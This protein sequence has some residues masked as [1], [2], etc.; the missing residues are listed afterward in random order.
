MRSFWLI[1]FIVAALLL[2]CKSKKR[3]NEVCEGP[4]CECTGSDCICDEGGCRC[5][6]DDCQC[7]GE[8]CEDDSRASVDEP[9]P[10][11][12]TSGKELIAKGDGSVETDG[13]F[14][15]PDGN[16]RPL[17]AGENL[18]YMWLANTDEG[19]V[20]K[21]DTNTGREV[22]RYLVIFPFQCEGSESGKQC[23]KKNNGLISSSGPRGFKGIQ[24][25][26]PSRT[27]IDYRGDAWV[28]NR[29]ILKMPK[30]KP[31]DPPAD[32]V[33]YA[34]VTKIA[35]VTTLEE[36]SDRCRGTKTSRDINR[37]GIIED[38]EWYNPKHPDW[39]GWGQLE[40][41]DDCVLFTTPV[42]GRIQV[43][44]TRPKPRIDPD[45]AAGVRALAVAP[46]VAEVGDAW[47]GCWTDKTL[48][49]LHGDSGRILD[50]VKLG[51]HPYGA[52]ADNSGRVWAVQ[53]EGGL[54]YINFRDVSAEYL[55]SPD[56]VRARETDLFALQ[57]VNT[58]VNPPAALPK[59][60][61]NPNV[62]A[63][64]D[65]FRWCSAYGLGVDR[66]ERIWVAGRFTE[67]VSVCRY[68][69]AKKEWWH[70]G[71]SPT[72]V[73]AQGTNT[74]G[75]IFGSARAIAVAP[76]GW[77]YVSGNGGDRKD[78]YAEEWNTTR[79]Q[80]M[81]V[82]FENGGTIVPIQTD[83]NPVSRV[84]AYDAN[85]ETGAV[86]VGLDIQ[87]NVWMVNHT[88]TAIRF[89]PNHDERVVKLGL[90]TRQVAASAG[91][92]PQPGLYTYSDFTG[93]QLKNYVP[94]GY[95]RYYLKAC[96]DSQTP[97]WHGIAWEGS[98]PPG[99]SIRIEV[100]YGAEDEVKNNRGPVRRDYV[101]T[102]PGTDG[103]RLIDLQGGAP[104]P[105]ISIT[106]FLD[107]QS[108]QVLPVLRDFAVYVQCRGLK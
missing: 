22:A 80:F 93:Y 13:V 33:K 6:G 68:D 3:D 25:L 39:K 31:D 46:G 32:A 65:A 18:H 35:H 11:A 38:D 67:G 106:F 10:G 100:R 73:P 4:S 7:V 70:W 24:G 15:D 61:P 42:C 107:S 36:A 12:K 102:A 76:N 77:V 81:V 14:L 59:V 37:N 43:P 88:G 48:V 75:Q 86:G 56:D 108:D 54:V 49:H 90:N 71:M 57:A 40:S 72:R 44:L 85:T 66:D 79:S 58:Q 104:L 50:T 87:N 51:I 52:I 9:F 30:N 2:G 92:A 78:F 27:A 103:Q 41:Y 62:A 19:Y 34:S 53:K 82:D 105:W 99:T 28:G 69:P 84:S 47:A 29:T 45:E 63:E 64:K 94:R 91:K 21:Y 26:Q 8:G 55:E 101:D 17:K 16:V 83:N 1:V 74:P 98:T 60:S 89:E 97:Y 20:S 95:I 5:E 96:H 23:T